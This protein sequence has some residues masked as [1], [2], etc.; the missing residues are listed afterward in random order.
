MR[1]INNQ[2]NMASDLDEK[3]E[4][5]EYSLSIQDFPI[6]VLQEDNHGNELPEAL[7]IAI[8]HRIEK[9]KIDGTTI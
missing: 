1:L 9:L 6:E 3:T 8:N 5:A 2:K 7:A 4:I